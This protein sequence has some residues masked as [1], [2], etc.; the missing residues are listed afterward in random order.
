M[1]A[2]E[3][4]DAGQLSAAIAQLNVDVQS[5]PTDTRLRTFLFELLCFAG[6][7]RRA[8]RQL[9][10]LGSQDVTTE[11]GGQVY[12]NILEAEKAR[13]RLFTEGLQPR[14][15]LTPPAYVQLHLEAVDRLRE[16]RPAEVQALLEQ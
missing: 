14:F 6:D 3:R 12:R 16:N 7:Y 1:Q 9:D 5:H 11:V 8:E 15:L 4:F 10:V 13:S 2:K